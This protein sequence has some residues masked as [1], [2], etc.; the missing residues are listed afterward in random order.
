MILDASLPENYLPQP[1]LYQFEYPNQPIL[2]YKGKAEIIQE[3]GDDIEGD[4]TVLLV[5]F[6]SPHTSFEFAYYGEASLE[7]DD[8][9]FN[10]VEINASAKAQMSEVTRYIG[11]KMSVVNGYYYEPV[12]Q[13]SGK[14]LASLVFYIPNFQFFDIS[15]TWL[16]EVTD[17]KLKGWRTG[18]FEGQFV[19]LTDDWRIALSTLP[20]S[21]NIHE[22]LQK[23]GGYALTHICKLERID[24]SPFNV[25][26]TSDILE[27]FSCYLSFA[28]GI[29][30][31]PILQ[32]GYEKNGNQV[33]EEWSNYQADS[34]QNTEGWFYPDSTELVQAFPGFIRRWDDKNQ[35]EFI[36]ECIHWYVES[37]KQAGGV[38]G[39]IVLQQTALESLAWVFLVEEKRILTQQ[40]FT[41]LTAGGTIR[42]LLSFLGI[43]LSIPSNFNHLIKVSREFNWVDGPQAITEVRNAIA[44]PE[45]KKRRKGNGASPLVRNEAWNLGLRYLEMVLLKLFD[46]P[47]NYVYE[48]EDK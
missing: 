39:A 43:D 41:K 4:V 8:F 21:W 1:K 36:S 32:F 9:T 44:H 31:A 35:R 10:L 46:Y 40:D 26:D 24:E 18:F 7:L 29:R 33:F 20:E 5:W 45:P 14:S 12:I 16:D 3:N 47:Y 27:A 23:Q 17:E 2:L 42:L 6:P 38:S 30:L 19:F 11:Q 37:N 34:W 15:N 13:G 28:R 25:G 48:L 22:R